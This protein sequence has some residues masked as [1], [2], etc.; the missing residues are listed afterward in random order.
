MGAQMLLA[1]DTVC[2]RTELGATKVRELIRD[3]EL[4]AVRVGKAI[5]ITAESLDAFVARLR[6]AG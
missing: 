4:E 2:E 5:R 6:Q 1:I 3:G